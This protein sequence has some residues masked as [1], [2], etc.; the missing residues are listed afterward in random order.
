MKTTLNQQ[1]QKVVEVKEFNEL[2]LGTVIDFMYGAN[3][4]NGLA[5]AD[6]KSL[7]AMADLY[8]MEDLKAAVAPL[9]GK[10]L[11]M[12]NIQEISLLAEKHT[13]QKLKG[14]CCDFILTD[15]DKL[16]L[17]SLNGSFPVLTVLGKAYLEKQKRCL[18]FANKLL[19]VDLTQ[20][21]NF[22]KR[23]NFK[24]DSDY[25]AYV[26]AN[27]KEN[28]IVICNQDYKNYHQ[29]TVKKGTLGRITPGYCSQGE[30]NVKWQGETNGTRRPYRLFDL[31]TPP[32][33]KMFA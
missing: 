13:A 9:I 8:K 4:P 27:I 28:M 26:K 22:K 3:I 21:G 24:S 33:S 16:N 12:D 10:Q 17:N 5:L 2:V 7:L 19:G 11:D 15:I 23:D 14:L 25:V 29:I 18:D 1:R 6:A 31:L 30:A 20:M 32:I